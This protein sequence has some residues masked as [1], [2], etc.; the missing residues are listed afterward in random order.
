[1]AV[2]LVRLRRG[3]REEGYDW[4]ARGLLVSI[5][6]TQVFLFVQSQFGAVFGLALD[7]LL[8]ITVRALAR[9]ERER[10]A[11]DEPAGEVAPATA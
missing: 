10:D 8:L 5:F 4:I 3:R 6:I 11:R 2:G 9:N 1:M 7:V